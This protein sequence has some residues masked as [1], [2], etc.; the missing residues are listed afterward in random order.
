MFP[1]QEERKRKEYEKKQREDLELKKPDP[2]A[3]P[4]V[5]EEIMPEEEKGAYQRAPKDK[6]EEVPEEKDIPLGKAEV[7]FIS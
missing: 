2:K 3:K 4:V 6:K 5:E 1:L 7:T